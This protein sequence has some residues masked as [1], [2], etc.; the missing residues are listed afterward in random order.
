[1]SSLSQRS[2]NPNHIS[3]LYNVKAPALLPIARSEPSNGAVGYNE[4]S[5]WEDHRMAEHT[6]HEARDSNDR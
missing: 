3:Y 2:I 6:F 1:M 5:G 4:K